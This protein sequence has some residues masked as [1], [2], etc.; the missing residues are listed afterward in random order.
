M[1]KKQEEIIKKYA[2]DYRDVEFDQDELRVFLE[3]F[4]KELLK[5]KRKEIKEIK[6]IIEIKKMEALKY[7][8][9]VLDKKIYKLDNYNA[10]YDKAM[11]DIIKS[12]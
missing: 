8:L 12:L 9:Q 3:H 10:G 7:P 1:N 11:Q 4:S 6:E 5:A 2:H